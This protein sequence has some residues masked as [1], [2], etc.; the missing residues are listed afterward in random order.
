MKKERGFGVK[1]SIPAKEK[2]FL[3]IFLSQ[4]SQ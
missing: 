1:G 2:A 3:K 4:L